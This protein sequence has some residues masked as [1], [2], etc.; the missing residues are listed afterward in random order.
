MHMASSVGPAFVTSLLTSLALPV[1]LALCARSRHEAV[2][3]AN[4]Y[5]LPRLLAGLMAFCGVAFVG[6]SFL[7]GIGG[8]GGEGVVAAIGFFSPFWIAAFLAAIYFLRYR[9]V[10]TGDRI[11][12]RALRDR[13]LPL[14]DIVDTG[15]A[16]RQ[17]KDLLVYLRD[18]RRLRLSGLLQDVGHLKA[19]IDAHV[20][21]DP[22]H[23]A[24]SPA[25]RA[26]EAR[27]RAAGI[28]ERRVL[29]IGLL[30]LAIGLGAVHLLA[31][32]QSRAGSCLN[33][34]SPASRPSR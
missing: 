4:V 33:D 12:I 7:P 29:V 34:R 10:M 8:P 25:K 18:G 28:R 3:G 32:A 17:G 14:G 6:I 26:D 13:S 30:V 2:D 16:P 24:A 31:Q 23:A 5:R 1:I 19:Q 22:D 9:V 20:H 15:F 11:A 27:D 21:R